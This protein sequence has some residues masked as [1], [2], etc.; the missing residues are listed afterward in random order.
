MSVKKLSL[1]LFLIVF[2]VG[3]KKTSLID[4]AKGEI[5]SDASSASAILEAVPVSSTVSYGDNVTVSRA[6]VAKMLT[7]AFLDMQTIDSYEREISF[8]D[9]TPE[10]WYDKFVN[11]AYINGLM[12]G[13]DGKFM[14]DE[15]ITLSQAQILLDKLD[16]NKKIK[17][18]ITEE[19]KDKPISYALWAKLFK[20][21]LTN[22]SGE[23]G[24][25]EVYS[26]VERTFV[27][28]ATPANNSKLTGFNMI[29]DKGPLTYYGLNMDGYIDKEIRVLQKGNDVLAV[30]DVVTDTPTIYSAYVV[31]VEPDGIT[32]FSGGCERKYTTSAPINAAVG[33]ICDIKINSGKAL[34]VKAYTEKI[35][36]EIVK[37]TNTEVEFKNKGIVPIGDVFKVYS[38]TE[39]LV[40]WKNLSN[41]IVGTN[42]A[43]F[44]LSG[45]KTIAAVITK[46]PYP[47]NIRVAINTTGF[48]GLIHEGVTISGTREF[49]ISNG[50]EEK[51]YKAWE[52]VTISDENFAGKPRLYVSSAPDGKL[53]ITSIKRNWSGNESPK[54]RGTLEIAK[55]DGGYV[56]VNNV[57]FEQYLYAV[58]PSE[59]PTSYGVEAAKVQAITAR[60]YAYN[61]F[62]ENRYHK[63]G[64][65]VDDSVS[66][67]VYN[68]T[69]ENETSISAVDATKGELLSY[70]GNVISAN[71]FSTSAGYTANSGEVWLNSSTNQFP[72]SSSPYLKSES[73]LTDPLRTYGDLRNEENAAAFF[74]DKSVSSFDSKFSWFRWNTEMTAEE[75]SASINAS[76]KSRYKANPS[77]IKTLQ[78]DNVYKVRPV[79]NIGQVVDINVK[80]R[81]QGG[82]IMFLEIK[83][84]EASILV[85]TEYNIRNLIS[86]TQ[87][88][89]GGKDIVLK[90][91]DGKEMK[92]YSIMPSAF[93]TIEKVK[94]DSGKLK[95]VKFFGAGNGHGV[96]MSQN[97]V[98]GMLD[99]GYNATQIL[100]HYYKGTEIIKLR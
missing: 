31:K 1:I 35:N 72:T 61:Q 83:G 51:T 19:T 44:Y 28:L 12:Q 41:L 20:D 85:A 59:M 79:E 39:G 9:V 5:I 91:N 36:D 38:T 45:D 94:D 11:A 98:K 23:K 27:V 53:V 32:I 64:A 96:G 89:A 90:L 58:V 2:A 43:D 93:Y 57:G 13:S 73:Q 75:I 14:P 30:L 99:L 76:L 88:I 25:T 67:Q 47:E 4:T 3:C 7:L 81:G 48:K 97:G 37:V 70:K 56:I 68:N 33:N 22:L 63:Y 77:L 60:S 34:D 52:P 15:P 42:L 16:P 66:C 50:V 86:P 82:N 62:Y 18:Q 74:K 6:L 84:T 69:P 24:I 95:S 8:S 17:L 80:Q 10:K 100:Q 87:R 65:N 40:K 26:I 78:S 71:F 29:T 46:T 21:L 49:T 54:Y 55:Q 92:N